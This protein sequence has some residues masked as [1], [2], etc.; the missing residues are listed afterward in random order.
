LME[1][2]KKFLRRH[3]IQD[4]I[5]SSVL[6]IKTINDLQARLENM[7]LNAIKENTTIQPF[8]VVVGIDLTSLTDFYIVI[9][10]QTL[11]F[12]SFLKALDCCFKTFHVFNLK[13]SNESILVWSFLQIY[14]YNITTSYDVKNAS[15]IKFIEYLNQ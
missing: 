10:K 11:K 13:Y 4:S 12:K 5:S 15:I 8:I 2:N 6:H 3:T 1:N 9:G 14:F 7:S